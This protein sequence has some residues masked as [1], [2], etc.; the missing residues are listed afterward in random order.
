MRAKSFYLN[1]LGLTLCV[2]LV[3]YLLHLM[4]PPARVHWQ[5][6][7]ASVLLFILVCIGLFYAGTNAARSSNKYA[8]NNLISLSVFGKMVLA[9]VF[10]YLY[11]QI[12]FPPNT[13]FV[14]IFLFCYVFYT[15]FEVW[16]MTKLARM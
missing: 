2:T 11:Q 10:L 8:F 9:I 4:A 16:F 12:A 14:G 1:L 5:L 6:S 3:L 13:W 15:G 7:I